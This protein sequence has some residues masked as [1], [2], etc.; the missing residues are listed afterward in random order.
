MK[1]QENGFKVYL[2]KSN[3]NKQKLLEDKYLL[4][5]SNIFSNAN[6]NN[7]NIDNLFQNKNNKNEAKE[8]EDDYNNSVYEISLS[9]DK[10]FMS[11]LISSNELMSKSL[12]FNEKLYF[13]DKKNFGTNSVKFNENIFSCFGDE[14]KNANEDINFLIGNIQLFI[15]MNKE[16]KNNYMIDL[17]YNNYFFNCIDNGSAKISHRFISRFS[18]DFRNKEKLSESS[19]I[20]VMHSRFSSQP[21]NDPY[22][23]KSK[24]NTKFNYTINLNDENKNNKNYNWQ[25]N[26]N[27]NTQIKTMN[28]ILNITNLYEENKMNGNTLINLKFLNT[29]KKDY[30]KR[31]G[32][33]EKKDAR[34]EEE[35]AFD[36]SGNQKFLCVKRYGEKD[37]KINDNMN[38]LIISNKSKP[39]SKKNVKYYNN[40]KEITIKNINMNYS[41][42]IIK[43]GN[44]RTKNNKSNIIERFVF[45]SP[46]I[47]YKNI[48]SPNSKNCLGILYKKF[49]D[50]INGNQH[51]TSLI[52]EK[53]NKSN[54]KINI[55]NNL[56]NS[57]SCIFKYLQNKLI[58][59]N[60]NNNCDNSNSY[61]LKFM[62][63][64]NKVINSENNINKNNI[65]SIK[66]ERDNNC[67]DNN[68]TLNNNSRNYS[69]YMN[70]NWESAH[71]NLY[72]FNNFQ[73]NNNNKY[74]KENNKLYNSV[75]NNKEFNNGNNRIY[76]PFSNFENVKVD[77]SNKNNYKYHEI[78]SS[79]EKSNKKI[80]QSNKNNS[81]SLIDK[82]KIIN[83][84]SMDN[85]KMLKKYNN[86][87]KLMKDVTK[88]KKE[89]NKY[90]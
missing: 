8:E 87:H 46:Q 18:K 2:N 61:N 49:S 44:K 17:Q 84:T 38:D 12:G 77:Y 69:T 66:P 28:R 88:D 52:K 3:F 19:T 16:R 71:K 23:R 65:S 89:K 78:K 51:Y 5:E 85:M 24:V 40:L 58:N 25:Y 75:R 21:F 34:L 36:S 29:T 60:I 41:N 10:N 74:V 15:K 79:K 11:N 9:K 64:F 14:E 56:K 54:I 37:N 6:D 27:E 35:Y 45:Y 20:P 59:K 86:L 26:T 76:F 83:L 73:N 48:F 47:S 62:N 32:D 43:K 13:P 39:I 33:I 67:D 53:V 70:K 55:N 72:S 30:M 1:K 63:S 80:N 31:N 90:K 57:K 50:K 22:L 7:S 4:Y 82:N 68:N 81:K 42:K